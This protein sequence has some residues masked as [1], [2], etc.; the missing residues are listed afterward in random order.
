M[1]QFMQLHFIKRQRC[2][3]VKGTGS[4]SDYLNCLSSTHE[5][6]DSRQ[7]TYLLGPEFLPLKNGSN[8]IHKG[9]ELLCSG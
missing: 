6:L 9:R 3:V 7:G 8:D 4:G 5:L 1:A 2:V